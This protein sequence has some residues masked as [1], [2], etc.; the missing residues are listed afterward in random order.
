MVD[1]RTAW[2]AT[3][4][5][6][7]LGTAVLL[8]ESYAGPYL[9]ATASNYFGDAACRV[10][11][12]NR[13]L[14]HA[15][16]L[17]WNAAASRR[18]LSTVRLSELSGFA[19]PFTLELKHALLVGII[20]LLDSLRGAPATPPLETATEHLVQTHPPPRAHPEQSVFH[21]GLHTWPSATS[22][23]CTAQSTPSRGRPCSEPCVQ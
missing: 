19:L 4:A 14:H 20:D 12:V 1:T 6:E 9:G 18:Q 3:L 7:A 10:L 22:W 23:L 5:V 2:T 17:S 15:V 21:Q 11:S 13:V 8:G 16:V